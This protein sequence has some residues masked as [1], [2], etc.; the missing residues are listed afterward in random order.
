MSNVSKYGCRSAI[1]A[2]ILLLGSKAVN[3]FRRSTSSSLSPWVCCCIGIPLNFGNVGLKSESFKASG[4]LFSF[5]VPK[6]LNI[7]KI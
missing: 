1:L 6:T 2:D 5:G 3:P 7:L 4:Q